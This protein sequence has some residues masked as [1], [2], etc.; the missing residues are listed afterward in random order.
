MGSQKIRDNIM[1]DSFARASKVS[2][3]HHLNTVG[4]FLAMNGKE[5]MR[6]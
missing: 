6:G 4:F 3:P 1:T 5:R 2:T